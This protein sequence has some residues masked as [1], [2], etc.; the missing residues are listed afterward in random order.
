MAIFRIVGLESFKMREIKQV[1]GQRVG[2]VLVIGE[3][4]GVKTELLLRGWKRGAGPG[5]HGEECIQISSYPSFRQGGCRWSKR[6]VIPG[7][8]LTW[9]CSL[10]KSL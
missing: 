3:L 4:S 2:W 6:G 1:T 10:A 8:L 7:L 5:D 9:W